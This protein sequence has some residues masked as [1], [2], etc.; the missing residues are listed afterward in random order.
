MKITRQSLLRT[1]GTGGAN[2]V[3]R[4]LDQVLD[5]HSAEGVDGLSTAVIGNVA[6]AVPLA[7]KQMKL[8]PISAI[9]LAT[10]PA[11]SALDMNIT[12]ISA[13]PLSTLRG[14]SGVLSMLSLHGSQCL[15]FMINYMTGRKY[16]KH[17]HLMPHLRLHMNHWNRIKWYWDD[18][19]LFAN[20]YAEFPCPLF[21]QLQPCFVLPDDVD[22]D[23]NIGN[24]AQNGGSKTNWDSEL[25]VAGHGGDDF[26]VTH[27]RYFETIF[28]DEHR[29]HMSVD[30]AGHFFVR[31]KRVRP[32]QRAV[33]WSEGV[34]GSSRRKRIAAGN[35]MDKAAR[36]LQLVA[37]KG[38]IHHSLTVPEYWRENDTRL[39]QWWDRMS[40]WYFRA[41]WLVWCA[42]MLWM[43]CRA[44]TKKVAPNWWK[45]HTTCWALGSPS[46]GRR[47]DR[48]VMPDKDESLWTDLTE[49]QTIEIMRWVMAHTPVPGSDQA[50]GRQIVEDGKTRTLCDFPDRLASAAPPCGLLDDDGKPWWPRHSVGTWLEKQDHWNWAQD[51]IMPVVNAV[52]SAAT[53]GAG[54]AVSATVEATTS[55]AQKVAYKVAAYG[56]QAL[57][58]LCNGRAVFSGGDLLSIFNDAFEISGLADSVDLKAF[59]GEV[60]DALKTYGAQIPDIAGADMDMIRSQLKDIQDIIH[61]IQNED[62][63]P[64]I[65]EIYG[66]VST[67]LTVKE[68]FAVV[69]TSLN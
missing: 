19:T 22:A 8:A 46:H 56:I 34:A 33:L 13:V 21:P 60:W 67:S 2:L 47:H 42:Q 9:P 14:P 6:A 39:H 30:D 15:A 35:R 20:R 11:L 61:K 38:A 28:M 65:D 29:D 50:D 54:S 31:G 62:G 17:W 44:T 32:G 48:M 57:S 63:W 68:I 25:A 55:I 16:G 4:E 37:G 1:L 18:D 66:Q 69:K 3:L 10:S 24:W 23:G 43:H 45:R 12:P 58:R 53:A 59:S 5:D 52:G 49:E 40:Q 26:V 64:W 7:P 36:C 27:G 41:Q 51:V